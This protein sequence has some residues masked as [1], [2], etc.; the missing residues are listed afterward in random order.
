M[1]TMK[2]HQ[3]MPSLV[4]NA[5][6]AVLDFNLQ[7]FRLQLG[8]QVLVDDP[9]NLEQIRK[10]ECDVLKVRVEKILAAG[11]NVIITTMGLDEMASKYL[12]E[13]GALG[14]RRLDK[15]H[16]NR[17]AK[18][19]GA[20]VITTMANPEGEEYFDSSALGECE[21]VFE[22]ALGDNDF[23]F[24]KGCKYANACTVVVRGAN[25]FMCEEVERSLHDSICVAKRVLESGKLVVGGGAVEV[26]LSVYLEKWSSEHSTKEQIAIATFA[27]AL[28]CIPKI[29]ANNAAKDAIDLLSKLRVLHTASQAQ[30]NSGSAEKLELKYCG[31]DLE[32]GKPRNNLKAGVL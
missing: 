17:I 3:L 1:Q 25:E 11:A 28:T 21:E 27:E 32:K 4:K 2:S 24:F 7:K 16:A 15:S 8:V 14:I 13:A 30:E 6:L 29:L 19:T 12:L 18:L 10:K 20:T 31:L 26:A 9:K 23:I 5:K 22:E